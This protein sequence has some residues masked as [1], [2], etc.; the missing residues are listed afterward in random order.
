MVPDAEHTKTSIP[1][2]EVGSL[3]RIH[4]GSRMKKD[5]WRCYS[6]M[7]SMIMFNILQHRLHELGTVQPR[8]IYCHGCLLGSLKTSLTVIT[9]TPIMTPVL[10]ILNY[11]Y[12]YTCSTSCLF[13]LHQYFDK[14]VPNAWYHLRLCQQES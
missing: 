4:W 5:T 7:R 14:N 3:T 8:D 13:N 9:Y 10:I 12:C 6:E 11:Y 2:F 1:T